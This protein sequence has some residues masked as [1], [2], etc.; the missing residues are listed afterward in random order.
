MME[1]YWHFITDVWR[2]FRK[3]ADCQNDEQFGE[4]LRDMDYIARRY[5]GFGVP[6]HTEKFIKAVVMA[7]MDEIGFNL[8]DNE[9]Q[10]KEK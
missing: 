8:D 1:F 4:A 6:K 2:V 7:L 5:I 3:Y 9:K 10:K